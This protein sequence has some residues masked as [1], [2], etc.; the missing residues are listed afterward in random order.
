MTQPDG[1]SDFPAR[2]FQHVRLESLTY[3]DLPLLANSRY[4]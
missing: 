2:H 4:L 1:T 3:D